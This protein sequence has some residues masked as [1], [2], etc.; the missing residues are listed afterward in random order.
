M[1]LA[2]DIGNTNIALGL[3]DGDECRHFWRLSSDTGRTIDEYAILLHQ[4]FTLNKI[5]TDAID[6]V[7]IGSVVPVLS[8]TLEPALRHVVKAR[9]FEVNHNARMP[10]ANSYA[11]PREVGIDRLANAV[12]GIHFYG[13]P[14]IVVDIGTAIT[15]D[16][17]S[18]E[19]EYLGG[20]IL[21][22][23]EMSADALARRTARLPLI[24]PK[25]PRHV[26]GRTTVES[27]R[28]GIL[29]GHV[30]AIDYLVESMWKELGY[31][32]ATVAT[33]G[34]APTI[35]SESRRVKQVN[36]ELTLHGLRQIYEHNQDKRPVTRGKV[37]RKR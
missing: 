35:L 8:V 3:F 28:S 32:T 24:A 30:G 16:V 2:L 18:R 33:G 20:A 14:L 26:I 36:E 27:I 15:L 6:A 29:H 25:A 5:D 11:K 13:A 21:P 31:K 19:R 23:I 7:V 22:G 4:L 1:L 10:V 9:V 12:G 34:L 17:I 37:G